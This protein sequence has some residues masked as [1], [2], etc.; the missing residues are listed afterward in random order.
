MF[1]VP[2]NTVLVDISIT[3]SEGWHEGW[4]FFQTNTSGMIS[5]TT[6]C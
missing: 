1:Y 3:T 4:W 5:H 2:S 6:Q